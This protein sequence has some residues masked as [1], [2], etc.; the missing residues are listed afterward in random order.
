M[1]K[2]NRYKDLCHAYDEGVEECNLYRKECRDFVQELKTALIAYLQCPE[3][4]IFMFQPTKGFVFKSHVLQ[5][6]VFDTEFAENGTALIGFALNVNDKDIQDKFFTFI[7]L[8][9]KI[10]D[11]F[12]FSVLDDEKEFKSQ[13]KGIEEFCEYLYSIA[14]KNLKERLDI[15]LESPAEESAPIGFKVKREKAA[16]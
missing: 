10:G 13:D 12:H 14:L 15:F 4:K 7:V 1:P 3:T 2:K 6:D 16:E 8:F 9:K 11:E 5:G